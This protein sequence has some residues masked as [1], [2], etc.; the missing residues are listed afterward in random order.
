MKNKQTNKGQSLCVLTNTA[1]LQIQTKSLSLK[2]YVE[3][4]LI[5]IQLLK[6]GGR[7]KV[8]IYTFV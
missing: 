3:P 6:L 4:I 1:N 7:E 8:D 2:H 5:Y